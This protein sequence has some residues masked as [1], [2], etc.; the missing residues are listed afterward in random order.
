MVYVDK[1]YIKKNITISNLNL[2]FN[3]QIN[4]KTIIIIKMLIKPHS[5]IIAFPEPDTY[6]SSEN[7]F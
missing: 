1:V 6:I 4:L 5:L 3:R 2:K 7:I